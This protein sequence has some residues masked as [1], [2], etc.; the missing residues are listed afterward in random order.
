[1]QEIIVL[2]IGIL[3][4]YLLG[5]GLACGVECYQYCSYDQHGRIPDM[6]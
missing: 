4:F 3:I 6:V 2:F 1:M 5:M